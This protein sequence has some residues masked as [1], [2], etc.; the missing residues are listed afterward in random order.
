MIY[1]SQLLNQPVWDAFGHKVGKVKDILVNGTE[2]NM[3]PLAALSLK[4]HI[5]SVDF[6]DMSQV[7]T[8]WPS[9]TLKV[10]Q[11]KLNPFAPKG[12]ELYLN[13]RRARTVPQ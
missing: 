6:V 10:D 13:E 11:T 9:I 12:H 5:E 2:K 1:L 8:L 4:N 7:A 3:P